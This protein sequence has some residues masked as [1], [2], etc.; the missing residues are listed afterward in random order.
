MKNLGAFQYEVKDDILVVRLRHKKGVHQ[1]VSQDFS[2]RIT[3]NTAS[4][5]CLSVGAPGTEDKG[6]H[7][8]RR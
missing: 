3:A 5:R 7:M 6:S 1:A 4:R 8:R 2:V